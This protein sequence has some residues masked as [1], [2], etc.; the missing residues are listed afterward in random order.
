MTR[1]L[2]RAAAALALALMLAACNVPFARVPTV[3]PPGTG[4]L[5]GFVRSED[6]RPIVDA[7][8]GASCLDL[9]MRALPEI[10]TAEDGWYDF[11]EVGLTPGRCSIKGGSKDG[12]FFFGDVM[13]IAGTAQRVDFTAKR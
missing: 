13:V 3:P 7:F 6:G 12:R 1:L 2:V 8:L 4:S 10:R 11:G 9:S 5:A